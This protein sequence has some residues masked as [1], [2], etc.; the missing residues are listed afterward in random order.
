[1]NI[2][3]DIMTWK[4]VYYLP[5]RSYVTFQGTFDKYT[6]EQNLKFVEET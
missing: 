5:D 4:W 1:M 2:E 3:E 6:N